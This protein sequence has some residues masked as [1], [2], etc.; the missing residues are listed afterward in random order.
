MQVKKK[1]QYEEKQDDWIDNYDKE[2]IEK[3]QN[4]SV[5]YKI[6]SSGMTEKREM[7]YMEKIGLIQKMNELVGAIDTVSGEKIS[8]S[9]PSANFKMVNGNLDIGKTTDCLFIMLACILRFENDKCSN[10]NKYCNATYNTLKL[11]NIIINREN[12]N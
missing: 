7:G 12:S 10:S 3:L 5:P 1:V 2:G 6:K 8:P 11:W 9:D 4:D